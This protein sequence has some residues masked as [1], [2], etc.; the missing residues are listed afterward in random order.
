MSPI[1]LLNLVHRFQ[2]SRIGRLSGWISLI[3]TGWM[4]LASLGTLALRRYAGEQFVLF[5][6]FLLVIAFFAVGATRAIYITYI[7]S[8]QSRA[9]EGK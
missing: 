6:A 4:A 1:E 8:A 3:A 7:R 9:A 5:D 2:T